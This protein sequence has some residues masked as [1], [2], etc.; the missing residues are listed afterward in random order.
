MNQWSYNRKH[1]NIHCYL[2]QPEQSQSTASVNTFSGI[3]SQSSWNHSSHAEQQAMFPRCV[4]TSISGYRQVQ[5]TS[6]LTPLRVLFLLLLDGLPLGNP[7]TISCRKQRCKCG[8]NLDS[9]YVDR[10][11]SFL[12]QRS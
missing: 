10:N 9:S 3:S 5:Y 6:T 8:L 4:V 12:L 7:E 11:G 1:N 2:L